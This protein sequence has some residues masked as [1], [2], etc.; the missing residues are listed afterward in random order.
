M[1]STEARMKS[2]RSS[3]R[4][5]QLFRRIR[6]N[7]RVDENVPSIRLVEVQHHFAEQGLVLQ[8]INETEMT[9]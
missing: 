1:N 8:S 7:S 4:N 3:V 2:P 9:A 6:Q 5:G